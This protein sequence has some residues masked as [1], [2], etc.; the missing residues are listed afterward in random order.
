MN[1]G[2]YDG[3][4]RPF[5]SVIVNESCFNYPQ[6]STWSAYWF[7]GLPFVQLVQFAS[8]FSLF[9]FD[10]L[11]ASGG[12]LDV[13]WAHNGIVTTGPYC[14]TQGVLQQ[15]GELGV[16]LI[17]LVVS[18]PSE[19]GSETDYRTFYQIL[20]VHTFVSALWGVGLHALR[21]AIIMVGLV[22]VFIALWV[23][24][25]VGIHN[26]YEVP[27]PV[28]ITSFFRALFSLLTCSVSIGAASTKISQVNA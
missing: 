6:T 5:P 14:T 3:I 21:F 10:I 28:G 22:C 24:I 18:S 19:F 16:A 7:P 25:G 27:S 1:S 20:A 4:G 23:G 26:N 15:V 17:T 13:R 2:T 12:I 8:Q 11:L 9:A